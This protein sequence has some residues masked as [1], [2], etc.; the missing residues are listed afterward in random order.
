MM[1]FF[2]NINRNY[3]LY[4]ISIILFFSISILFD[5]KI[6]YIIIMISI[7]PLIKILKYNFETGLFLLLWLSNAYYNVFYIFFE[8]PIRLFIILTP[9]LIYQ[10]IINYYNRK[11]IYSNSQKVIKYNRIYLLFLMFL[12]LLTARIK[13]QTLLW[14]IYFSQS[15][16]WYDFLKGFLDSHKKIVSSIML[17]NITSTFHCIFGIKQMLSG[18]RPFGLIESANSLIGLNVF[19]ILV[20]LFLIKNNKNLILN[21]FSVT[22][23]I[24][25]VIVL[26]G[27]QS[28]GGQ[29]GF[30]FSLIIYLLIYNINNIKKLAYSFVILLSFISVFV[31]TIGSSFFQRYQLV[32]SSGID[33]STLD[34][35]GMWIAAIK[36]FLQSPI[37]GIGINNYYYFYTQFHTFFKYFNLK[38]LRVAHNIY[39]NTLAETGLIGFIILLLLLFS[40]I[41]YLIFLLFKSNTNQ[42]GKDLIICITC[43]FIYFLVH[44]LFDCIWTSV[45]HQI[46][47]FQGV[48][49]LSL[50]TSV[51]R[52]YKNENKI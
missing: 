42:Q 1:Y 40:I 35:F 46:I 39:L 17:L 11:Y 10:I 29:I 12:S 44:N 43:Y 38:Q 51:E 36:L 14:I 33:V 30:L 22:T 2:Q 25:S 6:S 15:F 49:I 18:L 4:I 24:L 21:I 20:N 31:V 50:L 41:K 27:T 7:F 16:L 37:Y 9:L 19:F 23:I 13:F 47:L 26:I 52:I 5:L 28:R 3:L 34:R 45:N 48:F 32:S 8:I